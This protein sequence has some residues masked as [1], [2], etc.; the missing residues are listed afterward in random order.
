MTKRP[1]KEEFQRLLERYGQGKCTEKEM[2]MLNQ[3]YDS[4][5]D[6][7]APSDVA[8][9]A[10]LRQ[11]KAEIFAHI[12]QRIATEEPSTSRSISLAGIMRIA[13]DCKV[14]C[15]KDGKITNFDTNYGTEERRTIQSRRDQEK[16]A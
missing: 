5:E 7:E 13:G 2:E 8:D 4:F 16:S 10:R 9:Q 3:W 11:L 15:V 12:N 1:T 14:N 6:S